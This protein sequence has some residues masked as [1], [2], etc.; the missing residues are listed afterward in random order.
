MSKE[1]TNSLII[2]QVFDKHCQLLPNVRLVVV[3][4]GSGDGDTKHRNSD[5][6]YIVL[7]DRLNV[8][9]SKSLS[10]ARIDLENKLGVKVS[11]SVQ[12]L[13]TI[14]SLKKTLIHID[15]K[16]VQALI[17][18]N[19]NPEKVRSTFDYQ[20]PHI[21]PEYIKLYSKYNFFIIQ[22]LIRK[23]LIRENPDDG[24]LEEQRF[25]LVKLCMIALKMYIQY[26]VPD[27]F[28]NTKNINKTDVKIDKIRNQLKKLSSLKSN[29]DSEELDRIIDYV[30]NLYL[31]DF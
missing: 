20:I 21:E 23:Y 11:N 14:N 31:E 10:R 12:E 22:S 1:T 26:Y 2:D 28:S 5:L 7:I 27:E 13:R 9:V 29:L 30:C 25:T 4:C 3:M 24:T 15:G 16:V 18:A 6:D 17:E 19:K 8:A